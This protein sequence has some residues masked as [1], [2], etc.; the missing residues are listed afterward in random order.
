M[1]PARHRLEGPA[2]A[3]LLVLANSLGTSMDLW[4]PQLPVLT[5]RFRVLRYEHRGHGATPAPDGPYTIDDLGGDVVDLLDHLGE[6]SAS[7]AGISLGGMVGMWLAAHHPDRV[8]RLVLACTAAHLPPPDAWSERAA[9]VREEGTSSLRTTLLERW[10]PA[11]FVARRP[12]LAEL[13]TRMLESSADEGYAGC[14]EAIGAMDQRPDLGRITAPT[15]VLAGA[16]DPVTPP[17]MALELADGIP[18]A[19]LLVLASAAHLAN[20]AAPERFT[21]AL[22]EH[23]A[24]GTPTEQGDRTRRQVLG[25][26]H[27]DRAAA[28]SGGFAA[29]FT[30]LITRYA[31]GDIWTRPGLDRRTRSAITL[32]MLTVLGRTD[33]VALHVRGARRNGLSEVEIREVLLQAAVYGG[34]PAAR[35]A[36]T[37][38]EATLAELDGEEASGPDR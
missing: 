30:D 23:V 24:G 36:F 33:E 35:S 26:A 32:A 19:G 7:L 22:L 12:D 37:V 38:A 29:P 11:G 10:F 27:V 17:A 18:G 28:S 13:V 6:P 34:V 16:E 4:E 9:K 2:G 31:W 1:T 21:A 8:D 5:Q 3:P 15:L 20:L 25:D 14:C